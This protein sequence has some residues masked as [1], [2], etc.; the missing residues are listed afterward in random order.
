[1]K[2]PLP[3]FTNTCIRFAGAVASNGIEV[4]VLIEVCER[5]AVASVAAER[6]RRTERPLV[7]VERIDDVQEQ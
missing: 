5:D 2:V 7:R 1:M 4:L 6:L 3:P